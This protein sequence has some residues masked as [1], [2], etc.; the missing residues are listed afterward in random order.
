MTAHKC[1]KLTYEGEKRLVEVHTAGA[2]ND[3]EP[4]ISVWQKHNFRQ[5]HAKTNWRLFTLNEVS[6][7]SADERTAIYVS[8]LTSSPVT[9]PIFRS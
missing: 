3:G 9:E 8:G 1:L 6:N 7:L 2:K 4:A 5:P